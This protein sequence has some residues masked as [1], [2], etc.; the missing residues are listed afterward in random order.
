MSLSANDDKRHIM[1]CGLRTL[2]HGHWRL[3]EPAAASEEEA[4]EGEEEVDTEEDS[5]EDVN[6]NGC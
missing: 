5:G 2:P 6:Q 3:R 1:D 4:E